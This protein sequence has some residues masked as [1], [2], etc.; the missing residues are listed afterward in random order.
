M[1]NVLNRKKNH[2]SNFSDF[3]FF[4]YGYFCTQNYRFSMNFHD[5]SKNKNRKIYLFTFSFDSEHCAPYTIKKRWGHFW[6]G[7]STCPSLWQSLNFSCDV[8]RPSYFDTN[9]EPGTQRTKWSM[10]LYNYDVNMD[11]GRYFR[12][13]RYGIERAAWGLSRI[14]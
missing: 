12:K 5:N 6:R 4:N 3:Y 14:G 10:V 13:P 7:G 1:R 9:T 2:I 8:F 11:Y